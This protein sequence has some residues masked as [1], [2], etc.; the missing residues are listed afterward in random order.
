MPW[1]REVRPDPIVE[2]H[3]ETAKK[4][5]VEAGDW[6]WIESPRGRVMERTKINDGIHPQVIV[7]E[8]GWWFPEIKEVG[9]GWQI[10]NINLLTDNSHASMD[11]A[12]GSTNLRNCLCNVYPVKEGEARI[13]QWNG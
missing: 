3:P 13:P 6:V 12:I 9:H 5:G 2:I 10:S 1:L 4:I 7:A 8:H 11:P